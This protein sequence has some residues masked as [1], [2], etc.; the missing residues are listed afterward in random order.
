MASCLAS[1]SSLVRALVCQPSGLGS[2]PGMSRSETAVTR[3][4][5]IMLLP[6]TTFCVLHAGSSLNGW[7]R[8]NSEKVSHPIYLSYNGNLLFFISQ[9]KPKCSR[10]RR[11]QPTLKY[12]TFLKRERYF[13]SDGESI[14]K[15]TNK[16]SP[17]QQ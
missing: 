13:P 9:T 2:I 7:V 8:G 4:N 14:T 15:Y 11:I 10:R 17:A 16:S 1:Y 5:P 12:F 6:S 3:G